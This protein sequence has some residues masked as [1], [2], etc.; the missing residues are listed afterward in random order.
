[1]R[2][3]GTKV[4]LA[5]AALVSCR[6]G[7]TQANP[8]A[9][10]FT[11]RQ[12]VSTALKQSPDHRLAALDAEAAVAN[13]HLAKSALLP[14]LSFTEL[15]NRGN[16]PVFVFGARLRQ[17]RF[18]QGDFALN[19][20][21]RPTP[22]GNFATRFSGDWVAFDSW[23][24][25]FVIRSASETA[26]AIRSAATRADQEI[27]H[28]VVIG[29]QG[30][31][32]AGKQLDVARHQVE[33]AQ[34]LVDSSKS[35][36]VSGLAVDSDQLSAEAN[37]AVRQQEEIA[38]EGDLE[39]AWAELERAVGASIPE[40]ERRLPDLLGAQL[41]PAAL[42]HS[43][44]AAILA[45]PD[46]KSL[47]Q[48][49]QASHS[50]VLATHSSF[51]PALHAFGDW[52]Q[53]RGSFAGSGGNNWMAGIELNVDILPVAKRQRLAVARIAE[54]RSHVAAQSADEQIRLEVTRAW[55][56]Q[57]AASRMV[58]VAQAARAQ[59][60]ESLRILRNRYSAGL[61]TMTDLLRGEDTER[62]TE[63]NYW[64]AVSRSR[65]AWCDLRFAMG[66]LNADN[67]GD[68]E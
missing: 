26:S 57:Q 52:E 17:Q 36:V 32:I 33:T 13:Q 6:T 12:A 49:T 60:A 63:A 61:A 45:R 8:V 4:F 44:E 62:Q 31:L 23:K 67:L 20:L 30:V 68:F 53:D 22:L 48:A 29:Y 9:D 11:L 15:A 38:A 42:S 43:T 1:M 47:E 10:P 58:Q 16:D 35:R 55:Y 25:E 7:I 19:A 34:A 56:A 21:N 50:A 18:N 37:L 28:Q 65:V 40:A 46:R 51:A 2:I 27:V 54:E 14:A 66:T 39:I 59:T 5:L 3:L 41:E 24:T 64:A